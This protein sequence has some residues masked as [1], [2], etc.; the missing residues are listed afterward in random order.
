M[1][2]TAYLNSKAF[3]KDVEKKAT[4]DG[5]GK[6]VVEI[7]EKNKDIVV[8][9]ADVT[10]STRSHFFREKFPKRFFE[11]GVAEQNMAG[12]AAGLALNGKI[13]FMAA[14]GV[15]SPGRNW[16]FIRIAI[17]YSKANVKI[18]GTHQG[19]TAGPDGATHQA[20][21]DIALTRVL[22]NMVVINPSDFNEAKKAVKES[23]KH[24]GPVYIRLARVKTPVFTNEKATFEIGKAYVAIKGADVTILATGPITYEALVA[25]KKLEEQNKIKCEVISCPTIKP[26]DTDTILES[27]KKTRRVIT[28]EEHQ[29]AAGFGGAVCELLSEEFPVPVM[30]IGIKDE[31]GESGTYKQLLE[32]YG[33]SANH[34]ELTVKEIITK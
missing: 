31:F 5:Y 32:K 8:L 30:R 27:V 9:S 1:S 3:A 15:F 19:L 28:V 12:I 4:R 14:Y 33:L 21:E 22:P 23:A 7:G 24:E 17:C 10:E 11:V 25:A 6:A 18:V 20:L 2:D 13:P 26:L 34:I 16:D 29:V